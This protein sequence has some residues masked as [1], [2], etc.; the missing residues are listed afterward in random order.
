[1]LGIQHCRMVGG[2]TLLTHHRTAKWVRAASGVVDPK[3][4]VE[5]TETVDAL[6]AHGVD[7]ER[8]RRVFPR[9]LRYDPAR[10]R[11]TIATLVALGVDPVKALHRWPPLWGIDADCWEERLAV[12][13]ELNLDVAEVVTG[14]PAVLSRLPD[15][16]RAKVGVL[17]R[18][19]LDKVRVVRKCPSVFGYSDG[20]IRNTLIFLDGVGLDGVRVINAYPTI[21]HANVDTKLRPIQRF[22]TVTMGRTVTE[23]S[24]YPVIFTYSLNGRL[25]P[26]YHFSVRHHKQHLSLSSIFGTP[27]ERFARAMGQS[28]EVYRDFVGQHT[29]K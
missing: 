22:V 6:S 1:M 3:S 20:R 5:L 23:L 11:V 7:V 18:M 4:V 9:V 26:R 16:L 10:I 17:L 14:C 13:R 12:L 29:H 15:A 24:K 8:L 28:L 19:G 21:L 27:N 2:R 25:V